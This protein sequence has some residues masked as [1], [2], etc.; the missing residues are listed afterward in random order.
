MDHAQC[1]GW[2]VPENSGVCEAGG[3]L[4]FEGED[5]GSVCAASS[6]RAS[7]E[8]VSFALH[9]TLNRQV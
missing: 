9:P 2:K 8:Q 5:T 1:V 3:S 4:L 6:L 7:W